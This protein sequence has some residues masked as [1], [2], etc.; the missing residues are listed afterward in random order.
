MF[1]GK[2]RTSLVYP[3]DNM[4]LGRYWAIPFFIRTGG[5]T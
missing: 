4:C 5:W 3:K 2:E 1:A